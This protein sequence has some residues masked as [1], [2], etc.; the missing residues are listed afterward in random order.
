MRDS[1]PCRRESIPNADICTKWPHL[2][3]ITLL[4][5]QKNAPISL[6]I[7]YHCPQVTRPFEIATRGDYE[8]FGWRTSLGWCVVGA[9]CADVDTNEKDDLGATHIVALHLRVNVVR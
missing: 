3:H 8:P 9:A 6:L 5:Y 2:S 4:Q 7:G 1:V